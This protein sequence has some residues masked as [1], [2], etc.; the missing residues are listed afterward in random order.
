[1][2]HFDILIVGGGSVGCAIAYTL[3]RYDLKVAVAEKELD[4]GMGT[5][6]RNSGVVHAGFNN[7]PGSLMAKLCVAGSEGF[8]SLCRLL[9][10][11]YNKTGKLVVGYDEADKQ[12]LLKLI[13]QGEKNGVKGLELIDGDAIRA[14]EP[15]LTASWAMYSRNT[16]VFNP[17]LYSIHLAEAAA[18]NG[19]R[20]YLDSPVTAI[21]AAENG[22]I[23]RAGAHTLSCRT[24][25]NS[26]G[27]FADRISAMA[28]DPAFT[29]YPCRG[30][31]YLL[32]KGDLKLPV[33]P[34]PRPGVGGLGVHLTVTVD[35]NILIGPSAD[36]I[37][38]PEDYSTTE[39]VLDQ[40][41]A[42]AQKLLPRL[43]MRTVIGTYAGVRPKLVK[44]GEANFGDFVIE[45]SQRAK[46]LIN[47]IGIESPG[48]TASLPIAEMVRDI[49]FEDTDLTEK[50]DFIPTYRGIP[51]FA[52]LTRDQQ[53]L[54]IAQDP[55]FG[56]VVCRCETVTRAQV[57]QALHNPIGATGIIAVKNRT[58][59]TMG[60]CNGG[61][62]FQRVVEMLLS[63][64]K[65]PVD[66]DFKR[67]GDR[68]LLGYVKG[69]GE[70]YGKS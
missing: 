62:C 5:S 14:M 49:L 18:Q 69:V 4:V 42:E 32:D 39:P 8:E 64:G 40:L 45:R 50:P 26:A 15:G 65:A 25:V 38:A 51:R 46:H 34:V 17:F 63:E 33:Y 70:S 67:R 56:D 61:Y 7:R 23:V 27:L 28:G 11:P 31:Y 36:Y 30:E 35:G 54:L 24:L 68:P 12:A 41:R 9:D 43:N 21:D 44:K 48:I 60:R 6:G 29:I 59:V 3:S 22:Y 53:R 52:E 20:F 47:L 13:A 55:D 16:A 1:M 19:V 2:E 57:K 10:I 58:R 37:D 66:I